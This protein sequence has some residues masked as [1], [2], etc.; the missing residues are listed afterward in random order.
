MAEDARWLK[1]K[2]CDVCNTSVRK[3]HFSRHLKSKMHLRFAGDSYVFM[4]SDRALSAF[5]STVSPSTLTGWEKELCME[6]YGA[7]A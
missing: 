3:H 6:F 4:D 5:L 7:D 2:R 1:T